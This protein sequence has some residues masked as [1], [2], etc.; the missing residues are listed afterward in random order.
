MQKDKGNIS[1]NYGPIT[2]LPLM[3]LTGIMNEKIYAHLDANSLLQKK[4]RKKKCKGIK[5]HLL[6]NKMIMK[7]AKSQPKSLS[8]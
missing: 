1:S 6:S 7:N 4:R 3:L 5:D 8:M 2:C